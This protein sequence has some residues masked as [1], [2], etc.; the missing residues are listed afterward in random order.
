M[1]RWGI[2]KK[3]LVVTLVP[4][5]LT[6]LLLG[7]FF[8]YSWVKNI[9]NLLNDRGESLSRQLSAGAEYGLFTANRSLLSSLS[10]A[11]LEE[12]DVRSIDRKSVV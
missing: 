2:R 1:R 12:Q 6:T 5:L 4:T 7:L 10:T 9:E 11:L 8:T 3:V